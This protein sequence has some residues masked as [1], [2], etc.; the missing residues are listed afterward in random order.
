M[1]K[2]ADYA[3]KKLKSLNFDE[4]GFLQKKTAGATSGSKIAVKKRITSSCVSSF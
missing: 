2:T 1:K 4:L 3:S